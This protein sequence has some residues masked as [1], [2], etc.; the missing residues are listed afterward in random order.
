MAEQV[1]RYGADLTLP[2]WAGAARSLALRQPGVESVVSGIKGTRRRS[3]ASTISR[4]ALP[5]PYGDRVPPSAMGRL[6]AKTT[7]C[8]FARVACDHGAKLVQRKKPNS[9]MPLRASLRGSGAESSKQ[10]E[11]ERTRCGSA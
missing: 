9:L 8:P 2:K 7:R 3:A 4:I 1:A 6:R 11:P 10:A 5:L